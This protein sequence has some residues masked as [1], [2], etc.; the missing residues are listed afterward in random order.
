MFGYSEKFADRRIAR[1]GLT[2]YICFTDDPDLTSRHWQIRKIDSSELGPV[3]TSKMV[4]ILAHEFVGEYAES[5]YIDNTVELKI[6]VATIFSYLQKSI[7]PLICFRHP[8]RDCIYEEAKVVAEIGYDDADVI[9]R[10]MERYR[11]L[12]Y[13]SHAGLIAGSAL[14]RS[15]HDPL[16]VSMMRSWFEEVRSYSYRDQLSFNFVARKYQF[17]PSY[18]VGSVTNNSL[19]E[20]P[21]VAGP[22]LPRGFRDDEYLALHADV[23]ES[24]INPRLHYIKYG[25]GEGRAWSRAGGSGNL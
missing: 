1:D 12:G 22:R 17:E 13:P 11:A 3:K 21:V 23:R 16:L 18:F 15:H 19:L 8:D 24:K 20:W 7:S 6:P 25:A 9:D 10:Q 5:L 2:D 4:K 14:L